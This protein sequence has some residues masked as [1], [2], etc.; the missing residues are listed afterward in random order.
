ML[1]LL[2]HM[3][4]GFVHILVDVGITQK[5]RHFFSFRRRCTWCATSSSVPITLCQTYHT[6]TENDEKSPQADKQMLNEARMRRV[7]TCQQIV[8]FCLPL[9]LLDT[10]T[11]KLLGI[12][13]VE[14]RSFAP[15]NALLLPLS[16]RPP[17]D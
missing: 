6:S 8:L 2:S 11:N 14:H 13:D 5:C 12:Q 17:G 1:V 3:S 16:F 4:Y 15:S 10:L 9:P 7:Q